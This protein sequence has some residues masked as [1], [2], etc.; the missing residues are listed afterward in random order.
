MEI[1]QSTIEVYQIRFNKDWV[2]SGPGQDF[3]LPIKIPIELTGCKVVF[4][5]RHSAE[6][7]KVYEDK[8]LIRGPY[9]ITLCV[10]KDQSI[11]ILPGTQPLN[12]SSISID[13]NHIING[14]KEV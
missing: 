8:V 12:G 4:P 13:I 5:G 14:N 9:D 10:Y 11:I 6:V 2:S 1:E 3:V 7:T